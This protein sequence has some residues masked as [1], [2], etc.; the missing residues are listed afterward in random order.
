VVVQMH[1]RGRQ[2]HCTCYML[3]LCQLFREIGNMMVVQ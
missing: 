2:N 3:S 1:M